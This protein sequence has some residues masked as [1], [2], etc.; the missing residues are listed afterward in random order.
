MERVGNV[1]IIIK[2]KIFRAIK[3]LGECNTSQC[4]KKLEST[5]QTEFYLYNIEDI[6][7][8]L[9]TSQ[10]FFSAANI[11]AGL[12]WLKINNFYSRKQE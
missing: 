2:M 10:I 9:F 8:K 5:N 3:Y 1:F 7:G 12:N 6:I 11:S 4:Q